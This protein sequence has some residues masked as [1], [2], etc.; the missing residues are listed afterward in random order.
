MSQELCK[1]T[2]PELIATINSAQKF[3]KVQIEPF[4]GTKDDIEASDWIDLYDLL[5]EDISWS[6][7]SKIKHLPCYLRGLAIKWY[8]TAVKG[9]L[10]NW[11]QVKQTFRDQYGTQDKPTLGQINAMVWDTN[12]QTLVDYYQSKLTACMRAGLRG[13]L[14]L[15]AL[16]EGLPNN[17]KSLAQS[18]DPNEQPQVWFNVVQR[19]YLRSNS[20]KPK[21]VKPEVN[22]LTEATSSSTEI[23]SLKQEVR[24]LKKLIT[25]IAAQ[26][27]LTRTSVDRKT[28]T[29]K[30]SACKH[31]GKNN[32]SSDR[33]FKIIG[34]PSRQNK[35]RKSREQ[36]N[37]MDHLDDEEEDLVSIQDAQEVNKLETQMFQEANTAKSSLD[38]LKL[39]LS[40]K[41]S[42]YGL[43]DSGSTITVIDES[44]CYE[45]NIP[46][47]KK[48][49]Q[50]TEAT[51]NTAS[52]G[53]AF[54]D[55][56]QDDI[57]VKLEAVVLKL[58][59][60]KLIIGR[61]DFH[62]FDIKLSGPKMVKLKQSTQV[63]ALI[64]EVNSVQVQELNE[65]YS[66]VFSQHDFNVGLCPIIKCQ[67][68]IQKGT[69]PTEARPRRLSLAL[70]KEEQDQVLKLLKNRLIR[71]SY[72]SWSSGITF[73]V[74]EGKK[75]RLCGDYRYLNQY[76]I[77]DRY[78]IPNIENILLQFKG[79]KVYTTLDVV[80][81]YNHIEIQENHKYLS[82]R[83][84]PTLVY[85]NGTECLLD[86]KMLHQYFKEQWIKSYFHIE[87][88][89]EFILTI[90]S[91]TLMMKKHT[92][93]ISS[94]YINH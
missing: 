50:V 2:K 15:D 57:N 56:Q 36:T 35:P 55:V 41:V 8:F 91:Y 7:E 82:Q 69:K 48:F 64:A 12:K 49:I 47:Y 10:L 9:Q 67:I 74:K 77:M 33:C 28:P 68:N 86:L 93:S 61:N 73:A 22:Y 58:A 42:V 32:H 17:L 89:Q 18:L 85:S 79:A 51:A 84:Q 54:L 94:K 81:G 14:I 72:S 83:L 20:A 26:L 19:G 37:N 39:K 13:S 63:P 60:Q 87:I 43:I 34:Y 66:K 11:E 88:M 29:H 80:R 45:H 5:T 30:K 76:T 75:P 52:K 1:L 46:V 59:K 38:Y 53:V 44:L 21:Q 90:L 23:Q 3:T 4:N 31:C 92:S 71:P 70:Q 40:D 24:E 62:L 6:E 78:P 25:E 16:T 65:K 27:P